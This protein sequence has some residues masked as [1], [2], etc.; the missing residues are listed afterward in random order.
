MHSSRNVAMKS[1]NG[2]LPCFLLPS[3]LNTIASFLRRI[4]IAMP[5]RERSCDRFFPAMRRCPRKIGCSNWARTVVQKAQ[6][7]T[8]G[9]GRISF[10]VSHCGDLVVVAVAAGREIGVDTESARREAH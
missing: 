7:E 9:A 4:A 10:N 3:A 6:I 5:S 1:R 2:D 8:R